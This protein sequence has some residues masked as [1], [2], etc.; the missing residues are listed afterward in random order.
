MGESMDKEKVKKR[1]K[2]EVEKEMGT[3]EEP[4]PQRR[5]TRVFGD[6]CVD[7]EW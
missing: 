7:V 3:Y 2:M 5:P 1:A 4:E 6:P